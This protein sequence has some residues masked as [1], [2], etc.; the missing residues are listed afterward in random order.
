MTK[1]KDFYESGNLTESQATELVNCMDA[2]G[3]EYNLTHDTTLNEWYVSTEAIHGP[4]EL[5]WLIKAE[6]RITTEPFKWRTKQGEFM[7][8]R[9]MRTTHVFFALRMIWNHTVPEELQITPFI[10]YTFGEFYTP[11]YMCIAVSALLQE[12]ATR[13]DL[14][15]PF[16]AQFDYM[17]KAARKLMATRVE[18]E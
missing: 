10:H 1:D 17:C 6:D 5:N 11:E 13:T 8:T 16:K 2:M 3:I 18:G 9:D 15:G 14:P 12:L 4:V 7:L